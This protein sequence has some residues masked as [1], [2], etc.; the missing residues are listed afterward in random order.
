MSEPTERA[1]PPRTLAAVLGL[2]WV[3]Y[4]SYYLGRKSLSVVRSRLVGEGVSAG[5]IAAMDTGY[6]VAYAVGQLASGAVGDRVGARKLIGVGMI[7]S[8]IACAL[9]ATSTI[10]ALMIVFLS[11]DGLAQATGWPGSNKAIA[12][13]T[14]REL[15][16]RVMGVWA[17]CYQVGGLVATA[18]ATLLLDRFGWR[19]AFVLPAAWMGL[20]GVVI[21]LFLPDEPLATGAVDRADDE[22]GVAI[23]G[24]L[25][26]PTV[27]CYGASY[28]CI[29]L[30]R[31]SF[32]FWLPFYLHQAR[33]YS[34]SA[35]GYL[36]T[37]L[38][39]GGVVGTI[40]FGAWSDRARQTPRSRI[41][42]FG[43]L[44][45]GV[46]L[47]FCERA[48]GHGPVSAFVAI[49][50]VGALLFGPD[51]LL[52]GAAAQDLG[53]PLA[54]ATAVGVVNGVG[55]IGAIAQGALTVGVSSRF[56]WPALFSVFVGLAVAAAVALAPPA[57]KRAPS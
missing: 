23:R 57:L 56:G 54:A 30:I 43:L 25:R 7:V 49:A 6:L 31:Y 2:T 5:S 32:L 27:W 53:G 18:L 46:A 10:A 16:G 24:V 34:E 35:A 39:I 38:E 40:A 15:R 17:T 37:A 45:L 9:F 26:S 55:S 22:R 41:A 47:F 20:Y 4:A 50:V 52:S 3:A 12:A 13:H 1:S 42:A 33:G 11:L 19:S 29:K 36:S 51:A 48:A 8:A 28:F 21:L 44:G 14:T